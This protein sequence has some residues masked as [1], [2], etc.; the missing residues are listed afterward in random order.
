MLLFQSVISLKKSQG[1]KICESFH[2]KCKYFKSGLEKKANV[3][4]D[5][6]LLIKDG[7]RTDEAKAANIPKS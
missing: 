7:D 5:A 2:Q 3:S 6:P 1:A 4:R